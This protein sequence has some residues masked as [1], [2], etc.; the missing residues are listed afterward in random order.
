ML[1]AYKFKVK[2]ALEKCAAELSQEM[3]VSNACQYLEQESM[4][5]KQFPNEDYFQGILHLRSIKPR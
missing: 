2:K 3:S 4:M 5:N 1:L